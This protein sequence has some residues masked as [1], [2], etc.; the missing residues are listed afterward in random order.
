M[1]FPKHTGFGGILLYFRQFLILILLCGFATPSFAIDPFSLWLI[2][3]GAGKTFDLLFQEK[4]PPPLPE[5]GERTVGAGVFSQGA[6]ETVFGKNAESVTVEA[7]TSANHSIIVAT[8]AITTASTAQALRKALLRGIKVIV[9]TGQGRGDYTP[10]LFRAGAPVRF[11]RRPVDMEFMVIDGKS[12]QL[13]FPRKNM[14]TNVL[15]IK[16][17][18]ELARTYAREWKALWDSG[19]SPR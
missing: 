19:V 11:F 6:W 1:Y 15:R 18:P 16:D 9:I 14:Q 7:I 8:S 4:S 5:T 12:V 10:M 2:G 17:V 3:K 13:G